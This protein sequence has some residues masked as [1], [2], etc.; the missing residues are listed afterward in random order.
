MKSHDVDHLIY[1]RNSLE[2]PRLLYQLINL[3]ATNLFNSP[4]QFQKLIPSHASP[5][6]PIARSSHGGPLRLPVT[7]HPSHVPA[8]RNFFPRHKFHIPRKS[9]DP[10]DSTFATMEATKD[11]LSA[12][13]NKLFLSGSDLNTPVGDGGHTPSRPP[14]NGSSSSSVGTFAVKA[15]LAQMLKIC[16]L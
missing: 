1:H 5:T 10:R 8:S 9:F 11:V 15:G 16:S 12:I 2:Q 7:H 13:P 14:L 4:I 3:C 6:I